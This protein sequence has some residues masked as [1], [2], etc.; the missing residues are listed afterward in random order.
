MTTHPTDPDRLLLLLA[1]HL[2]DHCACDLLDDGARCD[3]CDVRGQLR[4]VRE[5]LLAWRS[6]GRRLERLRDEALANA[7]GMSTQRGNACGDCRGL[8]A[9]AR[10]LDG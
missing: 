6:A 5:D 9:L 2:H 1:D 4:T 3:A 10:T 7:L 8:V